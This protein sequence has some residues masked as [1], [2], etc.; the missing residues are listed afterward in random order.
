MIV[1]VDFFAVFKLWDIRSMA[2]VQTIRTGRQAIINHI[3]D[4]SEQ[5]MLAFLDNRVNV[6]KFEQ[7]P[8]ATQTH[9]ILDILYCQPIQELKVF[10][11][12]HLKVYDLLT[13]R[14]KKVVKLAEN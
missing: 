3:I 7:Q 12:S 2:C 8:V 9:G 5:R 14:C 6:F 13:G 11:Y 4:A 10:T 1:S